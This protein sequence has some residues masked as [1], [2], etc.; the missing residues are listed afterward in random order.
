MEFWITI[1]K[2][3]K[4]FA[5]ICGHNF[6]Y[7]KDGIQ[8]KFPYLVCHGQLKSVLRGFTEKSAESLIIF[9]PLDRTQDVVLHHGQRY[10]CN[11]RGEMDGLA[12]PKAE[13]TF[14]VLVGDFRCPSHGVNAVCLEETETE[15]CCKESVPLSFPAPLAEEQP[16]GSAGEL[17]VNGA[18]CALERGTVPA[19]LP[20]MEL[21]YNLLCREKPVFGAV[22]GLSELYHAYETAFYVAAV[23]QTHEGGVGKPA[24]NQKIVK[25]DAASDGIFHHLYCL[26]RLLH[27]VLPYALFHRLAAVILAETGIT[28][29]PGESLFP[30][31]VLAFFPMNGEIEH[32]LAQAVGEQQRKTLVPEYAL[33]P[34]MGEYPADELG[35][36]ASLGSI[37]IIN[38]QAYRLLMVCLCLTAYLAEQLYI[39]RIEQLAPLYITVIHKTIEHVFFTNEHAAQR[40]AGIPEGVP[41]N[42]E[43]EQNQKVEYLHVGKL[44]VTVLLC[45]NLPGAYIYVFHNTRYA[46]N[47]TII[48]SF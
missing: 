29:R 45:T 40:R 38:D 48:V 30:F 4:Q 7:L 21:P 44:A 31:C 36:P 14:L 2:C 22:S 46:V 41:D 26:V 18:I 16:D 24:V 39:K 20:C 34:D 6:C 3:G 35:L 47:C 33:V 8:Y 28:L 25:T 19:K 23:Y 12:F 5:G 42:K 1:N 11:L 10:T 13:Q 32:K 17:H 27:E 43:R 15:V 9:E 37:R